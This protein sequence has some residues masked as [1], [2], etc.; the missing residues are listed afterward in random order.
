MSS[1]LRYGFS[2]NKSLEEKIEEGGRWRARGRAKDLEALVNLT[3]AL[4]LDDSEYTVFLNREASVGLAKSLVS[5]SLMNHVRTSSWEELQ[6]SLSFV[7][8][9]NERL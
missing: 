1:T 5:E 3:R 7:S 4:M 2:D 9:R 6:D 8:L